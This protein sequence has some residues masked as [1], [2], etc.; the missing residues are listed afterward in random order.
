[1]LNVSLRSQLQTYLRNIRRPVELI[2]SQGGSQESA[3]MLTMLNEI[4]SLTD[5][6]T[7]IEE[8]QGDERKPSFSIGRAGEKPGIQFAATPTG[9]EF[10]SLVLAILQVGGHPVIA[11]RTTIEQIRTLESNYYF[12][13]YISLSCASC[14]DVVQALNMMTVIN[15]QIHNIT[16]DGG[17]FQNEV[18]ARDIS[19]VPT[20]YMNGELFGEGRSNFKDLGARLHDIE[21]SMRAALHA[22]GKP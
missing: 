22:A 7:V 11:D 14:V 21:M 12:E 4:A 1:M 8:Q 9:P 15:P 13:T 5:L 10:S 17:L 19:V 3:E 16:I 18:S 6:V 20:I 2:V